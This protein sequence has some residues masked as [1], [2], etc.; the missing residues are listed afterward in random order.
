MHASSRCHLVDAGPSH[1]NLLI[2]PQRIALTRAVEL[3]NDLLGTLLVELYGT[4][5]HSRFPT[6][7]TGG[8]TAISKFSYVTAPG[9]E[10]QPPK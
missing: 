7:F 8:S 1:G 10:R 3:L 9:I 4:T 5:S 6:S 2:P